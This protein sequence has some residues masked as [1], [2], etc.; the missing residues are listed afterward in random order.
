M[1]VSAFQVEAKVSHLDRCSPVVAGSACMSKAAPSPA[2]APT[3]GARTTGR[4]VRVLLVA[5]DEP[6]GRAFV[7]VLQRKHAVAEWARS[8]SELRQ[9]TLRADLG[10]PEVIFLDL[11][12]PDISGEESVRLAREGFAHALVVA[13]GENLTGARATGLLGVGVPYL[14]KPISAAT[15]AGL[16]LLLSS[17]TGPTETSP[18]APVAP[19]TEGHGPLDTALQ[20]YTAARALSKQQRLILGFYLSGENDKQIAQTISCSESTVYE[21]WRRMGKKAGGATKADVIT[22][23]HRFLMRN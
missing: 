19:A 1:P 6:A 5:N 4:G 16:A 18:T 23:F 3:L 15:L 7:E 20:A 2:P 12:L 17:P 21:H 9:R 22:D 10:A 8:G 14:D 13:L 11:E